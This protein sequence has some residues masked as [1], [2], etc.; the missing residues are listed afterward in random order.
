MRLR[1][2]P[3][4]IQQQDGQEKRL[5]RRRIVGKVVNKTQLDASARK[6]DRVQRKKVAET[7]NE[8]AYGENLKLFAVVKY[9]KLPG[10]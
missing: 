3:P 6:S 5:K 7:K 1:T 10:Y 9:D 2:S 8:P 4:F